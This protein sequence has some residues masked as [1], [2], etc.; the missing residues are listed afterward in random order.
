MKQS[1]QLIRNR[2]NNKQSSLM[3]ELPRTVAVRPHV[4]VNGRRKSTSV[5]VRLADSSAAACCN[6]QISRLTMACSRNRSNFVKLHVILSFLIS[7]CRLYAA[8]LTYDGCMSDGA[9]SYKVGGWCFLFYRNSSWANNVPTQD[10]A[11]SACLPHGNL[12]VGV[13]YKM[14]DFM[15]TQYT[16]TSQEFVWLALSRN[17]S[18]GNSTSGLNWKTLLPTGE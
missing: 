6:P 5:V 10:G 14:M 7:N 4:C 11:Q 17:A 12:A 16:S 18:S 2:Q 9:Q 15:K 8:V 1:A 13:T 3:N